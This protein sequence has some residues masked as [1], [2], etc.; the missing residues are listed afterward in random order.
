[1]R[2]NEDNTIEFNK[3]WLKETYKEALLNKYYKPVCWLD[4]H[5]SLTEQVKSI[6]ARLK[7]QGLQDSDLDVLFEEAKA[8]ALVEVASKEKK[9]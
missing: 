8:D 2:I 5:L 6:E 7:E 4:T 9:S 3:V 1:M